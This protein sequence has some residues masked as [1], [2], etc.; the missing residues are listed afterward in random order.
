[1]VI[2]EFR[3]PIRLRKVI[4]E[5]SLPNYFFPKTV[6]DAG[7]GEGQNSF[8]L[9][10]KFPNAQIFGSDIKKSNVE[11]CNLIAGLSKII[12]TTFIQ[13]DIL[14]NDI[15]NIDMIV[16]FEVLEHINSYKDAL[17][18]F[19]NSL[20]S[21]GYLIIHTPADNLFQSPK[22]G[23][24]K[25]FRPGKKT[26][27]NHHEKGQYH[28]RSG[29]KLDDLASE[30][31]SIGFVI[32]KK[33]YTFGPLAMFAHIIYEWSRSRSKIWQIITLWPLVIMGCFDM[34]LPSPI[35][36]GILIVSQKKSLV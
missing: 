29:F 7:C 24:R 18:S 3:Y 11:K 15:K 21:G 12:N 32:I 1:L 35:G 9:S 17:N 6:W 8:W 34:L 30:L 22:W 25:F 13:K 5:R 33:H 27:P 19:Q 2:G 36:G 10:K 20:V 16:C 31:E 28:V 4:L 23:L 14:K 26:S